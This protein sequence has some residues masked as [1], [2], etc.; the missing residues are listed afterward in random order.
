M[1]LLGGFGHWAEHNRFVE[2]R[3]LSGSKPHSARRTDRLP[4][5][6]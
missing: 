2:L 5:R 4:L 6:L 3:R 1:M